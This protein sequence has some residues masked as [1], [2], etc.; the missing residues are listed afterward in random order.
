[1]NLS[2][3]D[4]LRTAAV[5]PAVVAAAGKPGTIGLGMG[6]YG[7][8]MFAP[9]DAIQLIAKTGYDCAELTMMPGYN[10]EPEAVDAA[11]RK[12]IR[13]ALAENYLALPS[14]LEQ[15][16]MFVDD[17]G[18]KKNLERIRRDA[19]FGKDVNAGVG[20][21]APC[22][23]THIGGK[24]EDWDKLKN[25]VVDRLGDWARAGRE[26]DTVIAVKGHNLNF[27]DT[28]ER[29][30]WLIRQ[31]NSPWLRVLYDYSH[32]Q[33]VGETLG[34]TMDRLLSYTAMI[35]IKDGRN[36]TD[37]PG[38]ERLLPGDGSVN[39]VD[40]YK[41]LLAFGYE[42]Q[43][44]VEISGMIHSRPGYDPVAT[45][46]YCYTKVTPKMAEASVRRPAYE[47]G[48]KGGKG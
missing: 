18:H 48:G 17:F 1:M 39:Y 14:L 46:K 21:V 30:L 32:Y 24:P 5:A 22:V 20:G 33:A 10:T 4:F 9:V 37:K 47:K 25:M 2:R 8:R 27:N 38:F 16:P 41:R 42:G 13:A 19:Q 11:G 28:S 43:T 31:V 23:Q 35:S 36:Y 29:T 3:R 15:I 40:Y 45:V 44:V 34:G 26:M 12:K 6:N 7:L